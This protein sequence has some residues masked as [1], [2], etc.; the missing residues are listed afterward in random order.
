ME[1]AQ[2]KSDPLQ[3]EPARILV[4]D[5][6]EIIRNLIEDILVEE[7]YEVI[8]ARNGEEGLRIFKER[9]GCFDL[10]I[11]DI[12]M[13]EADGQMFFY[14][15]QKIKPDLTILLISGYSKSKVKDDLIRA[16]VRAYLPKPFTIAYFID[17]VHRL[18]GE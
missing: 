7:G 12:I 5:D 13:P 9:Q 17:I 8:S 16:G 10:I 3:K 2:K 6:E 18:L 4:V 1:A 11:L 15:A 14:R